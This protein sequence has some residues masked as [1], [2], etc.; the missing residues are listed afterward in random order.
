RVRDGALL[1]SDEYHGAFTDILPLQDEIAEHATRALA[2]KLD[3]AEQQSMR[4]HY[5]D[6]NDAY[7]QFIAGRYY[8][9]ARAS[10]RLLE[11]GISY[12]QQ[13]IA[14]DPRFA[15]AYASLAGCYEQ[16]ANATEPSF[17]ADLHAKAELAAR[18]ALQIDENLQEA[19]LPLAMAKAYCDWDYPGAESAFRRS[20]ALDP[21]DP[22]ARV[23]YAQFLSSQGRFPEAQREAQRAAELDPFSW[24]AST[25]I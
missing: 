2:L 3:S 7:Q 13:A 12:F 24:D 6:S 21:E 23:A 20:I 8:C 9:S 22:G 10:Q 5:T 4:R 18:H 19:Y 15:L 17:T 16:L 11:K 1:W 25:V 14:R